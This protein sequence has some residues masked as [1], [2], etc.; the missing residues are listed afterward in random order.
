MEMAGERPLDVL[1]IG[2]LHASEE[3]AGVGAEGLD[4]AALALGVDGVEGEGTLAG[5]GG[6]R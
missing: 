5:A 2:F 4:V 1:D 6:R 3:L